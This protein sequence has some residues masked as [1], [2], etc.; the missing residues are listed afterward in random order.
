[1]RMAG[2]QLTAKSNNKGVSIRPRQ[3]RAVLRVEKGKVLLCYRQ[4]T[5]GHRKPVK[6]VVFDDKYGQPWEFAKEQPDE[7]WGERWLPAKG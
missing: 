3:P 7:G 2:D 1:M 5:K 4:G 6:V